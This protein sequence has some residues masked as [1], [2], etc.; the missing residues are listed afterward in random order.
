[1]QTYRLRQYRLV[2]IMLVNVSSGQYKSQKAMLLAAGYSE[3]IASQPSRVMKTKSFILL[4]AEV[5]SLQIDEMSMDEKLVEV[6]C[7]GLKARYANGTPNHSLRLK[8]LKVA[9]KAKHPELYGNVF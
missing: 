8:Y 9:L 4:M 3:N 2:E 1:M 5:T 6:L 7:Q